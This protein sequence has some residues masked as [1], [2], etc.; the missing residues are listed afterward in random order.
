MQVRNHLEIGAPPQ[1]LPR[2]PASWPGGG[3]GRASRTGSERSFGGGGSVVG[4]EWQAADEA[5]WSLQ[6]GEPAGLDFRSYV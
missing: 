2:P 4:A 6:P 1:Y 3:D 5:E